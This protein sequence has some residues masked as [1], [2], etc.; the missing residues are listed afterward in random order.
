MDFKKGDVVE[1]TRIDPGDDH[2]WIGFRCE[3]ADIYLREIQMMP[4][5]I[6][7]SRLVPLSDRPDATN[8]IIDPR[9]WFY[10]PTEDLRLIEDDEAQETDG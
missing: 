6:K 1:I 4:D 3:I 8:P 5:L 10:W 7:H 2:R 9:G